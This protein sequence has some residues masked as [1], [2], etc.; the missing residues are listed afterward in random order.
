MTSRQYGKRAIFVSGDVRFQDGDA[1]DLCKLGGER[2]LP[3]SLFFLS[4]SALGLG[5][6]VIMYTHRTTVLLCC[7]G[8]CDIRVLFMYDRCQCAWRIAPIRFNNVSLCTS[9]FIPNIS[10]LLRRPRVLNPG[11]RFASWVR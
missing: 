9:I 7:G 11:C 2:F 10:G 3:S 1:V 6:V 4:M 5:Y 8:L